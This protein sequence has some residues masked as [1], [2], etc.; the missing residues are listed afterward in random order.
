MYCITDSLRVNG[1]SINPSHVL[2]ERNQGSREFIPLDYFQ[3][4]IILQ[5]TD[6]TINKV[7]HSLSR[8]NMVFISPQKSFT[9]GVEYKNVNSVCI[10]AFS[11][12]FYERSLN[13]GLLLNSELFFSSTSNI[14]I[15]KA[16]IPIE[17]V[18][19]LII[20]RLTLYKSK[21]N[22]GFYVSATHNC[23][24][25]LLL[26]GLLYIEERTIDREDLKK[27]TS[28]DVVNKFRI[29]LQQ[30]YIEERKV[31]FYAQKLNVTPRRLK[32]MTE[33][34]LGKSAKQMII[35]KIVSESIRTLKHSSLTISETAY[36]LGFSDE[37]N[38]S[39]FIK[40][41]T[42]KNPKEIREMAKTES[43]LI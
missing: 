27:F 5:D 4:H 9:V 16:S 42:Q 14:H 24:E 20:D 28:L 22:N 34:V 33:S 12:S 43:S 32:D 7:K 2:I 11:S 37:G 1:F 19:K 18:Q 10:I 17:E 39:A 35:E 23:I 26:D 13:D 21:N 3:I 8:G 30:H 6:I 36:K 15:T 38:F 40:A 25:A 29:L 41:H 31:S